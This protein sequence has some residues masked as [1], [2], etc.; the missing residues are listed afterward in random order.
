MSE[1]DDPIIRGVVIG[2]GDFS[3]KPEHTAA[4]LVDFGPGFDELFEHA[5]AAARRSKEEAVV[6]GPADLPVIAT[7]VMPQGCFELPVQ[8]MI[9]QTEVRPPEALGMILDL[10]S[11]QFGT[12][13]AVMVLL[14]CVHRF[15]R[16]DE[17]VVLP[18]LGELSARWEQG[19]EEIGEALTVVIAT[20]TRYV[21]EWM[22]FHYGDGS[23]IWEEPLRS[24]VEGWPHDSRQG[25]VELAIKIAFEEQKG[26]TDGSG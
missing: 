8:A 11:S 9:E 16:P 14:E 7:A 26:E 4:A 13:I 23:V 22:P 19:D 5:C 24:E 12:P 2:F 10:I 18:A 15:F 3:M 17:E 20:P 1:E 21:T 6:N 25:N